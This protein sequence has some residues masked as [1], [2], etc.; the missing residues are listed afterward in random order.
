LGEAPQ[1]C[2]SVSDQNRLTHAAHKDGAWREVVEDDEIT[3]FFPRGILI[4]LLLEQQKEGRSA[5]FELLNVVL[6]DQN[7][8]IHAAHE[9]AARRRVVEGDEIGNFFPQ[10]ILIRTLPETA[11][12]KFD[13]PT[14]SPED[15]KA[16]PS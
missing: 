14:Q 7:W 8:L 9:D 6:G 3:N 1:G 2:P 11:A 5:A 4:R 12:L 16:L 13:S 10:S 15:T